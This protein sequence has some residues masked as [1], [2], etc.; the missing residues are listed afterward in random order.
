MK[1]GRLRTGRVKRAPL[2]VITGAVA[3]FA[4]VIGLHSRA[5]AP[6]L[7]AAGPAGQAGPAAATEPAA[8]SSHPAQPAA[9]SPAPTAAGRRARSAT[10]PVENFGYGSIAVRITVVGSRITA[11]TVPVLDPL[12]PQSQQ[13]SEQA[14]PIL[15]SEVLSAQSAQIDGVSGATYTSEGYVNSLQAALDTLHL[16]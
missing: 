7:G 12:E 5:P 15:R 2:L 9:T 13:I 10:G 3:G 6:R 14:I 8:G 4:G 1:A 11:V 16:Q